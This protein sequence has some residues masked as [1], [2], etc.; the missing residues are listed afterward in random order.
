[1][2]WWSY[3]PHF[4]HS[5]FYCY[6]YSYGQL[7]VMALFGLYRQQ[8][9]SFVP[10]YLEFL[11]SGDSKAP[12]ELVGLFGFDIESRYFWE[13][14]IAEITLLMDEFRQSLQD[15]HKEYSNEQ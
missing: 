10:R 11:R 14:G 2:L 7:L 8:K 4:I 1:A 12:K 15:V 5:P 13:L 6:A 9:E 3:I